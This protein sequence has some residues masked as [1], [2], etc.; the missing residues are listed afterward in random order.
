MP[1][2]HLD[3]AGPVA[4]LSLDHAGG[5]R[6]IGYIGAVNEYVSPRGIGTSGQTLK[7]GIIVS[8]PS[9]QYFHR[10]ND[11]TIMCCRCYTFASRSDRQVTVV[12]SVEVGIS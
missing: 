8:D 2:T 12:T 5:N 6:I 10:L 4:T 7:L 3:I 11:T 9:L 1:F